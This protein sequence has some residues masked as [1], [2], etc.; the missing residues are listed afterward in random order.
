MFDCL[1]L[2][3]KSNLV[4]NAFHEKAVSRVFLG[5]FFCL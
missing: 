4:S 5:F 2:D 3:L 1:S